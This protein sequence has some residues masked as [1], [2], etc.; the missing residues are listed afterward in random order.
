MPEKELEDYVKAQ[1]TL[2][3]SDAAIKKSLVNAG[4][5]EAEFREL[6]EKRT[7]RSSGFN[8]NTKHTLY[9]N[10]ATIVFV[11]MLFL[12]LTND[13]N[14]KIAKLTLEEKESIKS[15]NDT[16]KSQTETLR[17]QMN[18]Q[19]NTL[20]SAIDK[21]KAE[22]AAALSDLTTSMQNY[23]YQSLTRDAT[24]SNSIQSSSN[25]S[26]TQLS[27]F[28]H[29]LKTVEDAA[30]DF[31]PIIPKAVAAVVT[32]GKKA[33]GYFVTVGSGVI[34]D[35]TGYLVTNY[36]VVDNLGQIFVKTHDGTDYTA[37]LVGKDEKWD[38]AVLRITT[39]KKNFEELT[40]ADSDKAFVGEH[41]IAI[42]NPIGLESTV[43]EGIISS[44]KRAVEGD[45]G[46]YY[47]QTDVAINAG[48]S[49]GPLIDKDGK[50]LGINTMKYSQIGY[51]G[52]SFAL[53]SN[54]VRGVVLK[55]LQAE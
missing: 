32:I 42:G 48:N 47:L 50:I 44:T 35:H 37:A 41:V 30:V 15:L 18:S 54:D 1:R 12:Y 4:Y 10:I 9:L 43:T 29:Q 52:L 21:N 49:G 23:N 31:T 13:Y 38:V 40:W 39:E 26:L 45:S 14:Q 55:I 7:I 22:S 51:E 3:V 25:N 17:T 5:D 19:V 24:L 28:Q 2:G 46:I 53:R 27:S 6:F 20:S 11:G 33:Q 34:I 16:I 8:V 36:H